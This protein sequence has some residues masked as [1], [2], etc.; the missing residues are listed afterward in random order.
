MILYWPE[1]SMMV[2]IVVA[3][4]PGTSRLLSDWGMENLR[5]NVS[6]PSAMS[7]IVTGTSIVVLV[8]LAV[9]VAVIGVEV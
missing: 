5:V 2:A 9:K 8:V 7:S 1:K 6:D 3:I 4:S